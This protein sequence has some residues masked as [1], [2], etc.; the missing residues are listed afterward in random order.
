MTLSE[1]TA[2]YVKSRPLCKTYGNTLRKRMAALEA[3]TGRSELHHV[4]REDV[5][6][7]FLEAYRDGRSAFTINKYRQDFLAVWRAAADEDLVPYPMPRRIRREKAPLP[8]VDCYTLAEARLIVATAEKLKG[9]FPDGVARRHYWPAL[10]RFAWD[11]GLRRGD[12]W[13][14]DRGIVQPD[15][16]FRIVQHKTLKPIRR[17]LQ[18]D[19]LKAID[20]IC[21]AKPFAWPLC[22][23]CFGVHFKEIVTHSGVRRGTFRWLRRATGSHVEAEHPGAG[24]RAL[25]NS[26]QVFDGHYNAQLAG[27]VLMPPAL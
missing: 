6:N 4:L 7:A 25:G 12:C 18:P 26:A 15:G 20:R 2:E 11:S 22:E 16:T 3:W 21:R 13:R 10:V 8:L 17:Q 5:I 23:W 27:Q 1:F 19:T 9:G 24:H 14:F